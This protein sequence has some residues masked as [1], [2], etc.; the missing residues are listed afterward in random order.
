[1]IWTRRTTG[2]R[3]A[4]N[5]SWACMD[6][7]QRP[8]D[9][10]TACSSDT[11][12]QLCQLALACL[13]ALPSTAIHC[14]SEGLMHCS[15]MRLC[16]T[17]ASTLLVLWLWLQI[18][19]AVQVLNEDILPALEKL[20]AE[21]SQYM[22]WQAASAQQDR[23][24]RFCVAYQYHQAEQCALLLLPGGAWPVTVHAECVMAPQ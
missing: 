18:S 11:Q 22:Q 1:M 8:E 20:R 19:H 15:T 24:K 4:L 3:A 23:L 21:R 9:N 12:Q 16:T 17:L 10:Q 13:H 7:K 6:V 2:R 14:Q 5:M